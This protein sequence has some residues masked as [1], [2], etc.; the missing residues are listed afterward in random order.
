MKRLIIVRHAKSSWEYPELTDYDRPLNKRG[1]RNAP[2]MAKYLHDIIANPG[3]FYSSPAKRA[4]ETAKIFAREYKVSEEKIIESDHL[5]LPGMDDFS[6]FFDKVEDKIEAIILFSHNPGLINLVDRL[7]GESFDNIP[8]CG[9]AMVS[10]E[11]EK[12]SNAI[13]VGG[14]L[15]GYHYPKELEE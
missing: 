11:V 14:V 2:Q 1:L 13:D 15:D 7:T 12:W 9:I 10:L 3:V 5:Y 4:L 8:T 6:A